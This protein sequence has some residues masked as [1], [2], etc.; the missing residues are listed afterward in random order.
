M[1]LTAYALLLTLAVPL[2]ARADAVVVADSGTH[3]CAK[4]P[5][6]SFT[7]ASANVKFVGTCD[8]IEINGSDGTFTIEAVKKL[9]VN[10][11][12]NKVEV[13]AADKISVVGA[14]NVV[15]YKKGLSSAKPKVSAVG[16]GNK[17][18]RAQ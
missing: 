13:G 11:S 9:L 17:V 1:K 14:A 6:A 4:D 8:K 16:A 2:A 3:D 12:T 5:V 15:T 18:S 7:G 10:G